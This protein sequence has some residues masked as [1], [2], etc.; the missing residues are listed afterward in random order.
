MSTPQAG[1]PTAEVAG[2]GDIIY[3]APVKE[4]VNACEEVIVVAQVRFRLLPP[5]ETDVR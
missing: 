2:G 5:S 1:P 4:L 3:P